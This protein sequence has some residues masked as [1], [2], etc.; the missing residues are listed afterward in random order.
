MN[1]TTQI[2]TSTYGKI[3]VGSYTTKK[4]YIF[5]LKETEKFLF[6]EKSINNYLIKPDLINFLSSAFLFS[7]H[8]NK[9]ALGLALRGLS[10]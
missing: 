2:P 5:I 10:H 7:L 6:V 8:L 9:R 4:N 3:V 1:E